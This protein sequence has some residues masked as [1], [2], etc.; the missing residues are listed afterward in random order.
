MARRARRWGLRLVGMSLLLATTMLVGVSPAGATTETFLGNEFDKCSGQLSVRNSGNQFVVVQRGVLTA[1]DIVPD[2]NGYWYWR[3]G[4][5]GE[6][7]R[8]ASGFRQRVNR[9]KVLHSTTNRDITW[10]CFEVV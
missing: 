1:V 8:G 10:Q 7:S 9:L 6:R 5:S 3:C 4:S 2:G